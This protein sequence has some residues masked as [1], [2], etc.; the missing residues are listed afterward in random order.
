MFTSWCYWEEQTS[1]KK[2]AN[3]LGF[4]ITDILLNWLSCQGFLKNNE[5]IVILKYPHI[6]FEYYFNKGFIIFNC[7]GNN[8]KI[9]LSQVKDRVGAEVTVNSDKFMLCYTTIP[10]I[11]NTLKNL[12]V[13]SNYH[14]LYT[15]Q[16][17]NDKK[18]QTITMFIIYV[19]PQI[20]EIHHP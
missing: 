20:K 13:D 19:A 11:S 9:L 7:D 16:G 8:L 1:W 12:L 14:P 15:N 18:E 4:V 5:Y 17:F 3:I 6:M 10:S 2:K